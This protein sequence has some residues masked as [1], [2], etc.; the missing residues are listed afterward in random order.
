MIPSAT[1][2]ESDPHYADIMLFTGGSGW[3]PRGW[4]HCDGST[5]SIQQNT[6]MFSLLK[7]R[8]GGDGRTTFQIP[9]LREAEKEMRIAMGLPE[10]QR[11]G[12]QFMMAYQGEWPDRVERSELS[13]DVIGMI[14]LTPLEYIRPGWMRCDGSEL[15]VKNYNAL[16]SLIKNRYGGDGKTTIQLPDLHKAEEKLGP[17]TDAATAEEIAEMKERVAKLEQQI[18]EAAANEDFQRAARL[19]TERDRLKEDFAYAEKGER[20]PLLRYV[21]CVE[22]TYPS[23]DGG[24]RALGGES[25]FTEMR[26]FAADFAPGGWLPCEGQKLP[27]AENAEMFSLLGTTYGGDGR[28][29]LGIPDFGKLEETLKEIT[30][31]KESPRYIIRQRG[32]FPFRQ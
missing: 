17:K 5:L 14:R 25:F 15:E 18:K 32:V 21:I 4:I 3:A 29:T 11:D 10:D 20:R 27:T 7:T 31:M 28:R 19:K 23:K 8:F 13:G 2:A 12:P 24:G 30:G 16:A 22:G 9:D 6:A 1:Q 26:L